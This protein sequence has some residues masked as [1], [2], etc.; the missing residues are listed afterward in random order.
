MLNPPN[1]VKATMKSFRERN[2]KRLLYC[3]CFQIQLQR[4]EV[5]NLCNKGTI[6]FA[7]RLFYFLW[8][9]TQL[10]S[11][12][13]FIHFKFNFS[14]FWK[15]QFNPNQERADPCRL[16][17]FKIGKFNDWHS[18]SILPT[19][20]IKEFA[21]NCREEAIGMFFSISRSIPLVLLWKTNHQPVHFM[22]SAE[23]FESKNIV[24]I[25]RCEI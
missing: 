12:S 21:Q 7:K 23:N 19:A 16:C 11:Y 25:S 13:E 1:G 9:N 8:T 22:R 2:I 3:Q 24:S 4:R 17:P 18:L 5:P 14:W 15:Y 10:K 20:W 6:T